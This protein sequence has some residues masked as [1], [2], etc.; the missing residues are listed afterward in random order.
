[1]L[2]RTKRRQGYLG[3][4][5]IKIGAFARQFGI[6]VDLLRLYEREGLI[7][8]L[9]SPKGTRY[10]TEHDTLWV[11]TILR[12]VRQVRLNFAGIRRLLALLPCWELRQC[13]FQ[14]KQNCPVVQDASKPC[15]MNRACCKSLS[16]HD[17]YFCPVYRSAPSSE[18]L[19]ALLPPPATEMHAGD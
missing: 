8:P 11:H 5:T 3:N 19:K 13:G 14:N 9:K 12:L 16:A 1:M 4:G 18:N 2:V 17:C 10:F 7:I 15:W 6:S